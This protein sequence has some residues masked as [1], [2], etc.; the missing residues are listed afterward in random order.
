MTQYLQIICPMCGTAH[1]SRAGFRV[2]YVRFNV[3]N[4]WLRLEREYKMDH[5]FGVAQ[6]TGREG[7]TH[8]EHFDVKDERADAFRD[9]MK[10]LL[11]KAIQHYVQIG[12]VSKTEIRN[13]LKEASLKP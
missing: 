5:P 13:S 6:N 4:H 3:E 1:G 7:F 8:V 12:V 10:R 2:G 11:L 9:V